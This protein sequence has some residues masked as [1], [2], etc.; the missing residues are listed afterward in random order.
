[1]A[2]KYTAADY[3]FQF[4]TV[5]VGMFIA[6]FIN[7]LV[8]WNHNRAL[9]NEARASI[10]REVSDNLKE[11]EGLPKAVETANG[12][13]DNALQFANDLIATGKTAVSSLSLNFNLA[14]LNES[15][16]LSADRTGALSNMTYD[17]VKDYAELYALQQ[18]FAEQQR[19]AVDLVSSA[20]VI[21]TV[22]DPSKA[23]KDDLAHFRE[24]LL[25]LK[26]NVYVTGQL[27]QQLITAYRKFLSSR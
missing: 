22:G 10:R 26:S 20:L 27:G 24:Q 23:S 17:Q 3:T 15:S 13:V 1:M 8:E 9:V 11:L 2:S 5:T 7:G 21:A 18:L 25:L 6:L 19:K 12:E 4:I 16:W 14:T